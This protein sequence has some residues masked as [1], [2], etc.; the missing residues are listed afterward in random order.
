MA[1][2]LALILITVLATLGTFF[3]SRSASEGES[4]KSF[5]GSTKAFWTAEA[6]IAAAIAELSKET[7]S[8]PLNNNS[9]DGDNNLRY[10]VLEPALV[11]GYSNRWTV[12]S[13]GTYVL[14]KGTG[15]ILIKRKIEVIVE[16][17]EGPDKTLITKTIESTGDITLGGGVDVC[18]PTCPCDC[19]DPE[20]NCMRTSSTLD[21]EEV[22]RMTKNEVKALADYTATDPNTNWQPQSCGCESSLKIVW[23]DL[24]GSNKYV[25]S[26][27]GWCGCGILIVN[28][29]GTD[30][31]LDMSGGDFKGVIWVVGKLSVS[32]NPTITGAVFAESGADIDNKLTGTGQL[33]FNLGT[34]DSA[35]DVL[36]GKL[37]TEIISWQE[38]SPF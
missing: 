34:K 32:G 4:I 6:G 2:I 30:V 38:V 25:V 21:F 19:A 15:D 28:G 36:T 16:K 5:I 12:D 26:T 11:D 1:L 8:W 37:Q 18:C 29:N 31:A 14:K 20:T 17:K 24:T 13:I 35:F 3:F 7:P 9:F 27:S 23:V 33:E 22:F 10:S